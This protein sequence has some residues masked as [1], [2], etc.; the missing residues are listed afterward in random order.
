MNE[1]FVIIDYQKDFVDGALGFEKAKTLENK[2]FEAVEKALDEGKKVFFTLDT[3]T[4]NYMSTREGKNLPV[5]HCIDESD[6]HRLYGMLENF[7]DKDG[8]V[9]VKKSGFGS[10]TLADIIKN[11]CGVPDVIEM[12]GVV[13]NMCV[14]A[15]AI[16][17]QTEFENADIRILSDMCAS[18]DD[19][20]HNKAID[21][22]KNMH[23]TIVE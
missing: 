9:M 16:V 4:D 2:I 1:I 15:N 22:M 13:T 17:L 7:Y 21:V 10:S 3:H 6:G 23:M 12:C 19:E 20:L 18:F 14:I 8:V 11:T 5:P